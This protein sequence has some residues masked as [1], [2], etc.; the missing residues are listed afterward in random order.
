MPE[1]VTECSCIASNKAACVLGGVLLI[2]SANTI[3]AKTG[4]FTKR[5]C[6][7]PVT[8]LSSIISVPVISLGIKSGVN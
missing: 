6:F 8:I 5:N 7:W 4:P 1:A 2:S 3:W